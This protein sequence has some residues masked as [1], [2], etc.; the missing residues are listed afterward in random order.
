LS[1]FVLDF[2]LAKNRERDL[3]SKVSTKYKEV[4]GGWKDIESDFIQMTLLMVIWRVSL[5]N[6][7]GVALRFPDIVILYFKF[8]ASQRH[9]AKL[10][11]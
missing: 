7:L 2:S 8:L 1:S 11:L 4:L 9:R 6:T 10:T 5:R 3:L